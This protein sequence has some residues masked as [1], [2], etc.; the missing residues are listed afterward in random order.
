MIRRET[1]IRGGVSS[2]SVFTNV[3]LQPPPKQLHSPNT[4]GQTKLWWPSEHVISHTT[5]PNEIVNQV[6]F[7]AAST[8]I[9]MKSTRRKIVSF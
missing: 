7:S 8:R 4:E 5:N 6:D 9:R 3:R 2:A 1:G